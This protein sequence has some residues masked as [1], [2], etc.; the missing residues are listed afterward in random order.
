MF[1][2]FSLEVVKFDDYALVFGLDGV[3]EGIF[4]FNSWNTQ[5]MIHHSLQLEIGMKCNIFLS[6]AFQWF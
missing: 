4:Q 2:D 6:S 1:H 3:Q 5:D